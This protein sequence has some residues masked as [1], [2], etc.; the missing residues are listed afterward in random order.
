MQIIEP[1]QVTTL[2]IDTQVTGVVSFIDEVL[3]KLNERFESS[4]FSGYVTAKIRVDGGILVDRIVSQKRFNNRR[5][6]YSGHWVRLRLYLALMELNLSR[7]LK[8]ANPSTQFNPA[9]YG[10]NY[11]Q[12][13]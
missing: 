13:L 1:T 9:V 7:E 4:A 12:H 3:L 5:K 10:S 8:S 11:A 2:D 6:A